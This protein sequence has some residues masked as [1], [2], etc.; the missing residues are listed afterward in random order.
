MAQQV[1]AAVGV[2][3]VERQAG[4]AEV[5][6]ALA[7]LSFGGDEQTAMLAGSAIGQVVAGHREHRHLAAQLGHQRIA[8]GL[9]E[10]QVRLSPLHRQIGGGR[11]VTAHAQ[12][13]ADLADEGCAGLPDA[14]RLDIHVQ[15]RHHRGIDHALVRLP[16]MLGMHRRIHRPPTVAPP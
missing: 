15:R 1:H 7:R 4:I 2:V 14:V 10:Q 5:A 9:R 6:E 12:A 8:A 16:S 13:P 11:R 3:V